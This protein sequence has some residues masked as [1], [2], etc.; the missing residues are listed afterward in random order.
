MKTK[1]HMLLYFQVLWMRKYDT[2]KQ[3]KNVTFLYYRNSLYLSKYEP[4]DRKTFLVFNSSIML[5]LLLNYYYVKVRN[6]A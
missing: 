3:Y 4:K 6:R 2:S 1:F 5:I